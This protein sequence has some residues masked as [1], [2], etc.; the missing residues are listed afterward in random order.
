MT[1]KTTPQTATR[2]T[3]SHSPPWATQ[4]LAGEPDRG[5]DRDEQRQPVHVEL[6]RP[7]VDHAG[8]RRRDEAEEHGR[9]LPESSA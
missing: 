9:I 3:R 1:P 4:R 7:H 2:V 8:V 5:E 6:K